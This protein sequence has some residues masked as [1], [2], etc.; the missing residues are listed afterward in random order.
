[1]ANT[2]TASINVMPGTAHEAAVRHVKIGAYCCGNCGTTGEMSTET[3]CPN[4]GETV[5]EMSM[6][7]PVIVGSDGTS[8]PASFI[9]GK[10]QPVV[11]G[12]DI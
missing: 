6:P 11:G 3:I 9:C 4:C 12:G 5:L 7:I 1:M 8:V 2:T 10:L